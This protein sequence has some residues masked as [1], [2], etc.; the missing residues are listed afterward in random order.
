MEIV[1]CSH[2]ISSWSATFVASYYIPLEK[3]RHLEVLA[4]INMIG[5]YNFSEVSEDPADRVGILAPR[6]RVIEH[7]ELLTHYLLSNFG[8]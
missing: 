6:R 4:V 5:S 7:L 3:G 8:F 2:W 1:S